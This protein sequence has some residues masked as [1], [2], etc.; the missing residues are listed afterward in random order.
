MKQFV[1][2][3]RFAENGVAASSATRE[4]DDF[5]FGFVRLRGIPGTGSQF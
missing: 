4:V 3:I 5:R 2:T 1:D